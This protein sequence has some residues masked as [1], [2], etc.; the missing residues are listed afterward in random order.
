MAPGQIEG[1]DAEAQGPLIEDLKERR[2][3]ALFRRPEVNPADRRRYPR[4][5]AIAAI[6]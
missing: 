6:R 2:G 4:R 1:F 5:T 3:G